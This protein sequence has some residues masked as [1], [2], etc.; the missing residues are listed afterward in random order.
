MLGDERLQL[1]DDGGVAT[2]GEICVDPFL[3]GAESRL[4]QLGLLCHRLPAL[5]DVDTRADLEAWLGGPAAA[6]HP[7]RPIAERGLDRCRELQR[8]AS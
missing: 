3:E 1:G 7:L 2:A 5:A 4:T 6:G 8:S